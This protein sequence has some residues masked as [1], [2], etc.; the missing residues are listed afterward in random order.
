[1]VTFD[2]G[3]DYFQEGLTRSLVSGKIEFY[4]K[5]FELKLSPAYDWAWPFHDG[6]LGYINKDGEVVVPVTHQ[7]AKLA[8]EVF[9]SD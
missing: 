7:S 5:D 6:L 1:V 4:N 9:V 2:N 8:V 3:A